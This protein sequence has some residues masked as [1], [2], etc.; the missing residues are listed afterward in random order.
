M[1][2][3]TR[4]DI[5]RYFDEKLKVFLEK[6]FAWGN[7]NDMG[8][9]DALL[10][11]SLAYIAYFDNEQSYKIVNGLLSCFSQNRN[12]IWKAWRSPNH[13]TD[14][15]SR[16]QVI[17]ALTAL[18]LNG[19][20]HLAK[21]IGCSLKYRLS[22]RYIMTPA[23]W[24]WIRVIGKQRWIGLF[25]IIFGM[26]LLIAG[27]W[28][29]LINRLL[30]LNQLSQRELLAKC[31]DNQNVSQILYA[32]FAERKDKS[33]Y[34]KLLA[35]M[36]IPFYSLHL[37]AW[38]IYA[39]PDCF[40]KRLLQK[41]MSISVPKY[42][43]LLKL[44]NQQKVPYIEIMRYQPMYNFRWSSEWDGTEWLQESNEPLLNAIDK[45]IL[46]ILHHKNRNITAKNRNSI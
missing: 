23:L 29:K 7:Q 24:L 32:D 1:L 46:Y 30:G 35:A 12:F 28:R 20:P 10:R 2:N 31:N 17:M 33:L 26:E 43:L 45:D 22:K 8:L 40:G 41:I 34:V 36:R 27:L 9:D 38:M 3:L 19:Y 44:L 6:P 15:V 16:D 4:Q 11:T 37:S 25:T 5:Y 14:D 18:K 21:S 13:K 39:M 42:N